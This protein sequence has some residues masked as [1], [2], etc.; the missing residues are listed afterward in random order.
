MVLETSRAIVPLFDARRVLL[1]ISNAP[2]AVTWTTFPESFVAEQGKYIDAEEL[3]GRSQAIKEKV[4][5]PRHP[6]IA[7][8]LNNQA[9][10]W[11]K[12]V[13]IVGMPH[14]LLLE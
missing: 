1:N 9:L 5:G 10:L 14:V 13:R 11:G 8:G 2:C 12:R 4:L 3:Y 7:S 6:D